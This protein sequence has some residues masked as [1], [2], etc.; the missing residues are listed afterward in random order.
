M[1]PN[2]MEWE[3]RRRGERRVGDPFH[4]ERIAGTRPGASAPKD[5]PGIFPGCFR[6][7]QGQSRHYD[8][9]RHE[10]IPTAGNHPLPG[11]RAPGGDR[12]WF[13]PRRPRLC[14]YILWKQ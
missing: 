3:E 8:N 11:G 7:E 9:E 12:P 13:P 1:K 6:D 5:P 2:R 14:Q 10:K 4:L